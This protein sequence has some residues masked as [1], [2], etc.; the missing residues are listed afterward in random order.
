MYHHDGEHPSC[1]RAADELDVAQHAA[2]LP[3][4]V[5]EAVDRRDEEQNSHDS[6]E[7]TDN[8]QLVNLTRARI[9]VRT[10]IY[11]SELVTL[12]RARIYVRKRDSELEER[13]RDVDA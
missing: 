5:A 10:I 12:D 3:H 9:Y 1:I 11:M 13:E 7:L 6:D 2:E 4:Q 8:E